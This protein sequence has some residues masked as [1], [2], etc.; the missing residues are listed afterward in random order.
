VGCFNG[1]N[2]AHVN[3]NV[4]WEEMTKI[5]NLNKTIFSK[6]M[7]K[8]ENRRRNRIDLNKLELKTSK[9][10]NSMKIPEIL[11]NEKKRNLKSE[12]TFSQDI[13]WNSFLK[14]KS[15]HPMYVNQIEQ[16]IKNIIESFKKSETEKRNYSAKNLLMMIQLQ[17]PLDNDKFRAMPQS[18]KLK[19]LGV[20]FAKFFDRYAVAER[21][22]N[23]WLEVDFRKSRRA[24]DGIYG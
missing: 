13:A 21:F 9:F 1:F 11:K 10:F 24:S 17:I 5:E 19:I 2:N 4:S 16:K 22:D 8:Q 15:M 20:I 7:S 6:P 12:N 23:F 18:E 3:Y 14:T